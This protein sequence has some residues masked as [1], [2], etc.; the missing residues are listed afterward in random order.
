MNKTRVFTS[1]VEL[2]YLYEIRFG[3]R[4]DFMNLSIELKE[5]P[6]G[7]LVML[8]GEV[9]IYT[10]PKLKQ[11]LIPLTEQS[12]NTVC[13]DLKD[14]TYLDSTGL[15]IFIQALK[16]ATK[17]NSHLKLIRVKGRVL[18]LFEVTGLEDIMTIESDTEVNSK[19]GSI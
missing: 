2:L 1:Y 6:N 13:I 7:Y 16:S 15:G 4:G 9:D 17:N 14:V 8:R 11:S 3:L 19:N 12:K 10:A 18:R 5:K